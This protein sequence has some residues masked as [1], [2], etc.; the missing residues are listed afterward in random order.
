MFS[1]QKAIVFSV[2]AEHF[3]Q[4][5][6]QATALHTQGNGLS[7]SKREEAQVPSGTS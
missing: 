3:E 5:V 1:T 6:L 7:L 2:A 4:A